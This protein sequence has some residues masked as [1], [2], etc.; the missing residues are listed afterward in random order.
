MSELTFPTYIYNLLLPRAVEWSLEIDLSVKTVRMRS[1]RKLR[2]REQRKVHLRL[3]GNQR[4]LL[5]QADF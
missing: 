2:G 1:L 3:A 5:G 4:A